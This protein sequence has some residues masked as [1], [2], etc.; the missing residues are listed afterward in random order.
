VLL[1]FRE[2]KL[3]GAKN[4]NVDCDWTWTVTPGEQGRA[5]YTPLLDPQ[6]ED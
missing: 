6:V 4:E 1:I 5:V 3:T 2:L